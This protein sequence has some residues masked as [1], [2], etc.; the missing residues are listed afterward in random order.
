MEMDSPG[1]DNTRMLEIVKNILNLSLLVANMDFE[2][3]GVLRYMMRIAL[4]KCANTL[5]PSGEKTEKTS[6][7]I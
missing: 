2:I 3:F 7:R 1:A 6:H 5:G 4:P